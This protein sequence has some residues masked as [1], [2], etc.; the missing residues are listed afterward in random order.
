MFAWPDINRRGV[1]RIRDIY[2]NCITVENSPNPSSVY[3]RLCKHRK[4]V[5]YCFYKITSSKNYN[6]GKDENSFYLSKCIFL[7]HQFNNG[8]SQLTN[9]NSDQS[10]F[11]LTLTNQNLNS[12]SMW[13]VYNF[14][15]HNRV[16]ILSCKHASQPIRACV[17]S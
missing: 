14:T 1:G 5:S 9:Q 7:Q 2:A 15:S 4:K 12:L 8:I 10:K 3:I 16:Y 11:K 13:R 17:L 6:A